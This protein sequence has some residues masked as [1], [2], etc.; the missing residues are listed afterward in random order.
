MLRIDQTCVYAYGTTTDTDLVPGL[1]SE[2]AAVQEAIA[3]HRDTV[4]RTNAL[5]VST[6][7]FE[8]DGQKLHRLVHRED[9]PLG[10]AVPRFTRMQSGHAVL[11]EPPV[12]D[13]DSA[14]TKEA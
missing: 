5:V 2:T 14:T 7:V 9:S 1:I 8:G 6:V 10:N 4:E 3:R 11:H 13:A 12:W